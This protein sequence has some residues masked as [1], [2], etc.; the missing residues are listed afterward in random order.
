MGK[1]VVFATGCELAIALFLKK[2]KQ[3]L[4]AVRKSYEHGFCL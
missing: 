2:I 3:F 1:I 4:F